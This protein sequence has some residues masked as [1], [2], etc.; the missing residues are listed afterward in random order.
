MRDGYLVT[1]YVD[2]VSATFDET[3]FVDFKTDQVPSADVF[4]SY[5]EYAE[6]LSTYAQVVKA[7]RFALLFTA[8]GYLAWA[9]TAPS[10]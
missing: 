5:P 6:Q 7:R 2:F 4:E 9:H 8:T 10:R 3:V 1:G